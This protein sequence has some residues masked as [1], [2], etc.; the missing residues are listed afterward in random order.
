MAEPLPPLAAGSGI[1][2]ALVDVF[3]D[4]PLSGNPLAVVP[5]AA[6]LDEDVMKRLSRE[7]NQSET[8]FLFRPTETRADWLLRSFTPTGVEVYGAGHNAL[9]AWW[10]L[11]DNGVLPLAEGP[12]A[13]TQQLGA[14]V[15]RLTI[16]ATGGRPTSV[17]M[18]QGSPTFGVEVKDRIGL[19]SAL[20][21][22]SAAF[23]DDRYPAQVVA[24]DVAHLMVPVCREGLDLA[25]PHAERIA[26]FVASHGGEGCYL[27]TT[28]TR[29]AGATAD[30]RFFNPGVGIAEDP[31][32]GTAAGPLAAFLVRLGVT[33]EQSVVIDQGFHAGRPSRLE[34]R[35]ANSEIELCG[36]A[37][38]AAEGTIRIR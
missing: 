1:P 37:V 9:G 7:F 5:P 21:L 34:V 35:V 18:L 11:A 23:L 2:F 31:A 30:A 22:E 19:A 24:T 17:G 15:H 33:S 4:T 26:S 12:N 38:V 10:W 16:E 27:F 6:I 20:G 3:T 14:R 8:T 13:F 28:S 36:R 25:R 29:D 32:T